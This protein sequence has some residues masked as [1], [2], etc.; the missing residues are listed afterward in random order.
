M[1][2]ETLRVATVFLVLYD[3]IKWTAVHEGIEPVTSCFYC[4]FINDVLILLS[5][6]L[7]PAVLFVFHTTEVYNMNVGRFQLNDN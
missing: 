4:Y 1:K 3:P 5:P 6:P 2:P 7:L